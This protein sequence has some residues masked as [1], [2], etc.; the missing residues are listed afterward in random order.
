MGTISFISM[1]ANLFILPVVPMGMLLT[2]L[3]SV[4]AFVPILGSSLAFVSYI[5]LAY[6]IFTVE[7][8]AKVP[9][10]ALHNISFPLWMLFLSYI[11]F[12]IFIIKNF[13]HTDETSTEENIKYDF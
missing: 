12:A 1:V 9:F 6:I 2:F 3:L 4:F 7:L 5:I 8:L 11:I 13:L 10:G